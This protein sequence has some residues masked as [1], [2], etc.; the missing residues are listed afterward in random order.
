MTQA[1]T[2]RERAMTIKEAAEYLQI[3]VE[4]LRR[5]AG[6]GAIPGRKIGRD[7]RF[8]RAGA[9]S[10]SPLLAGQCS[11]TAARPLILISGRHRERTR[12]GN[13]AAPVNGGVE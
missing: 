11:P 6:C 4:K 7:W 13:R 3:G 9:D 2:E 12:R 10:H 8:S 5:Q 1:T